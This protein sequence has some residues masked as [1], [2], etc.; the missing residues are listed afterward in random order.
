MP[1]MATDI[2]LRITTRERKGT[3]VIHKLPIY[4]AHASRIITKLAGSARIEECGILESKCDNY[5]KKQRNSV[6]EHG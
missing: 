1:M 3:G 6:S 5:N 4:L 2:L